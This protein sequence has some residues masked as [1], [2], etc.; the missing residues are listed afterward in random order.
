MVASVFAARSY[1]FEKNG[2]WL[3]LTY[4]L[5]VDQPPILFVS[6][7]E[8]VAEKVVIRSTKGIH[9]CAVIESD[10]V[11]PCR[12]LAWFRVPTDSQVDLEL[13]TTT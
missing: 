11:S 4:G 9:G 1:T 12:R 13:D 8:R 7:V 2:R 3:E 6:Y 5:D 10:E